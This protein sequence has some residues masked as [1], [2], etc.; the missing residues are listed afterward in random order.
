VAA[1]GHLRGV[2]KS[3]WGGRVLVLV[4]T[5][6]ALFAVS[7]IGPWASHAQAATGVEY[8]Q[9]E[10]TFF[11]LLNQH[12]A[13]YGRQPLLLSQS[14]SLAADRHSSDMAKYGFFSHFTG[15]ISPAS[16]SQPLSGKRTDWF[17]TGAAPWDRMKSCGY[18][19][20][21]YM[22]ENIAA[23]QPTAQEAFTSFVTSTAHNDAMLDYNYKVVGISLVY[24]TG[25]EYGYYWTL[26]FGGYVD[27]SAQEVGIYEQND[28]RITYLGPWTTRS[29]DVSAHGSSWCYASNKGAAALISFKGSSVNLFA[30]TGPTYG[31]AEISLDGG[32]T[33]TVDFYSPYSVYKQIAY[34]TPDYLEYGDHTL[35]I[36]CLGE[37]SS[38]SG[39]FVVDVDA[40]KVTAGSSTAGVLTQAPVPTRHQQ[41]ATAFAYTGDWVSSGTNWSASGGSYYYATSPGASVN[42]AFNGTYVAWVAKKGRGYG[43]A[44]VSLDGGAPVTVDLYS[45]RDLYKQKVYDTGLLDDTA[46]TLSIYWLGQKNAAASGYVIDVDTID[47]FGTPT[48]APTAKPITWLYQQNDSR[49]SYLG[50]WATRW[51]AS[52]SGGSFYYTSTKGAAAVVNFTGTS[53][54]LLAKKGPVYGRVEICLDGA[55]PQIVDLY[56][57]ADAFGQSVYKQVGLADGSHTLSIKCTGDKAEA[58]GGYV[59]DIDAMYINGG[60][61]KG[62]TM[63]RYQES[64][65]IDP[66]PRFTYTG[67][68][69][70]GL[71]ASA[72][73]GSFVSASSSG[74]EVSLTFDG[75]YLSWLARTTP[76]YGRAEVTLDDTEPIMVDLYSSVVGWQKSIYNTG[77]LNAGTHTVVIKWTGTRNALSTGTAISV[78]A[79]DVMVTG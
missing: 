29:G 55:A 1:T 33:Q 49:I 7:V 72:S 40:I 21:T 70:T 14:L 36:E 71:T 73:G 12:R 32:S 74:S 63:A 28:S 62:P 8:S 57:P 25:S 13:K 39:G 23:G 18:N 19:Y 59:V 65:T 45:S 68:W 16:A 66:R 76:W 48:A 26:D 11:N 60:M 64:V 77:L 9:D 24:V 69:S 52:A 4:M 41:D 37:K 53:V 61:T 15:C 10:L 22:G 51:T 2:R 34:T 6:A 79:A 20:N 56:A 35:T 44:L 50:P 75:T 67:S 46:H 30:K 78:D 5:L 58:S 27:P 43:K 42:V 54:D 47:V 3:H 38:A 17:W 31:K